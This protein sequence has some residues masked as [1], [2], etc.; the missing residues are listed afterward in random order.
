MLCCRS[1]IQMFT[2]SE[3]RQWRL[4]GGPAMAVFI[5]PSTC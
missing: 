2:F 5:G 1:C 4:C 3:W